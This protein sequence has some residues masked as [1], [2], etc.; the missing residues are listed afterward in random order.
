MN[1]IRFVSAVAVLSV[2]GAVSAD[3]IWV[4]KATGDDD[5]A[6]EDIGSEEHPFATIQAGV[7]KAQSGDTVMVKPGDYDTKETADQ[8]GSSN[9]VYITKCIYLKS[10]DGA[11]KTRIVG[12]WSSED[13]NGEAKNDSDAVRCI[14]VR[15]AISG[16]NRYGAKTVI[17]GF[18]LADGSAFNGPSTTGGAGRTIWRRGNCL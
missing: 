18:T 10:T 7:D 13:P 11:A 4:S 3:T 17:E 8:R 14:G 1:I 16:T 6:G 15:T 12:K 5:Y 9:R 2:V